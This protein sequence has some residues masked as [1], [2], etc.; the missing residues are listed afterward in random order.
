MRPPRSALSYAACLAAAAGSLLPAHKPQLIRRRQHTHVAKK[1]A[2]Q[3]PRSK[4]ARTKRREPPADKSARPAEQI[5]TTI[6]E[7]A[8][9]IGV[10]TRVFAGWMTDPAFPGTPGQPGKQ[11]GHFPI[12]KIRLWHLATHGPR[13]KSSEHDEEIAALKLRKAQ[14]EC[15]AEQVELERALGSI[16]DAD[17]WAALARRIIAAAKGQL[18]ELADR[19]LARLPA[20]VPGAVKRAVRAAIE[21]SVADALNTLAELVAGDTDETDDVP[22]DET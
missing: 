19:A 6:G 18:D 5:A 13:A 17:E 16:G 1:R 8:R 3:Q 22:D 2:K 4:P 10:S 11:N 20:K 12:E 9:Q 7:A 21:R 15:D 14:L